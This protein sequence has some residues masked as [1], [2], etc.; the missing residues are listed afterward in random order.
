MLYVC[1]YIYVCMYVRTHN[2][3][4]DPGI[5]IGFVRLSLGL[6]ED[7]IRQG[8]L[9]TG[10]PFFLFMARKKEKRYLNNW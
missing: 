10:W 1:V 5:G 2:R 8:A 6:T 3:V 9:P 4:L 7:A